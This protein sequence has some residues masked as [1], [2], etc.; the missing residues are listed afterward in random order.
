MQILTQ[1]TSKLVSNHQGFSLIEILVALLLAAMIFLAVPSG[2]SAQK[3]RDLRAAVDDIDRSIQ[4]AISPNV[5]ILAVAASSQKRLIKDGEAS[6]YFFP[7][8][9]KDGG[10]VFFN[11]TEEMAYIEIEPFLSETKSIYEPLKAGSIAKAE[12]LFQTRID[13]V[14]KEWLSN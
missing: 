7:T 2:D 9:E 14:Y 5:T 4:H 6:I 13:E 1:K 8:G 12:D 11:T 10:L 3:H